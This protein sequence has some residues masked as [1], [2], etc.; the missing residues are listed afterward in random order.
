MV[1]RMLCTHD[2]AGSSPVA[3][4]VGITQLVEWQFVVLYVESSNLSVHPKK[5]FLLLFYIYC[6]HVC[7]DMVELVDT[8]DLGSTDFVRKGS[9]PFVRIHFFI[10]RLTWWNGRH[11]RLKIYSSCGGVGSS[12]T[13]SILDGL[14]YP[15]LIFYIHLLQFSFSQR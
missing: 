6:L 4:R 12:P 9:S 10:M 5:S 14:K 2:V 3:S 11:D 15:C 8:V 7:A 1:E 13:V